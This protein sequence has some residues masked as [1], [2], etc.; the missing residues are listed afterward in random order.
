MEKQ[1][2]FFLILVHDE[3]HETNYELVRNF[4]LQGNFV[5]KEGSVL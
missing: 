3:L 4:R 5:S 1:V 2:A